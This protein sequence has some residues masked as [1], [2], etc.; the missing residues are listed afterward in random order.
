MFV[1]V[2]F[3]S[4]VVDV[5]GRVVLLLVTT[6]QVWAWLPLPIDWR[7]TPPARAQTATPETPAGSGRGQGTTNTYMKCTRIRTDMCTHTHA[8]LSAAREP[9]P[10][11]A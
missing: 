11:A 6:G 1:V 4:V 7:H 9:F 10:S 5:I 8:L 2:V 3:V